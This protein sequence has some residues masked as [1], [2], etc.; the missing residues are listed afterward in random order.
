MNQWL[1]DNRYRRYPFEQD[2]NLPGIPDSFVVD[3][4]I[5]ISTKFEVIDVQLKEVI[6]DE[7]VVTLVFDI[8]SEVLPGYT[9][10]GD[11]LVDAADET[12]ITLVL[13]LDGVEH[14]ELGYGYLI[15]G[16]PSDALD[17]PFN[18]LTGSYFS[19]QFLTDPP[20]LVRIDPVVDF[21][22]LNGSPDPSIPPDQFSVRWTGEVQPVFSEM[23][24]FN[25]SSDDGIRLWVN[26]VVVINNWTD[27]PPTHDSGSIA[28]TAN[29]KYSIRLEFYE[30]GGGAVASLGWQSGSQSFESI[31]A[32][33]LFPAD[34]DAKLDH[35]V[36]RYMVSHD[37]LQIRVANKLRAGGS[38]VEYTPESPDDLNIVPRIETTVGNC[39]EHATAPV[40]TQRHMSP[41][42]RGVTTT[43]VSIPS[44]GGTHTELSADTPVTITTTPASSATVVPEL[45][46]DRVADVD[47][48]VVPAGSVISKGHNVKLTGDIPNKTVTFNYQLGGGL[49][50]DCSGILGY[51]DALLSVDCVK[52]VNG[53]YPIGQD[54]AVAA[55]PGI[56][57]LPDQDGHRIV[58]LV[59]PLNLT[60]VAP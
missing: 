21:D 8:V 53:V 1:G 56:A 37:T 9:L 16:R 50:M 52:S 30:N 24:T 14:P 18:G 11:V 54:L 36:I 4:Q 34:M 26:N 7:G 58:L 55:D 39:N 23:Y 13:K 31:P 20:T 29:T 57:V 25:T 15:I 51:D 42:V 59:N 28:L 19:N 5:V 3:A 44:P 49:G 10:E 33:R 41:V 2:A 46:I 47:G 38:T 60:R 35:S 32:N 12:R 27:H 17:I 45:P 22:W 43:S 6:P 48:G 40:A